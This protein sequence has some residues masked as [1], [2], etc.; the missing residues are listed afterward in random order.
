MAAGGVARRLVLAHVAVAAQHLHAEVAHLVVRLRSPRHSP[1][2]LA[3][4]LL[5][6]SS[7]I[8]A[9]DRQSQKVAQEL[10]GTDKDVLLSPD[11]AF[12]LEAIR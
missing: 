7:V 9:R 5:K 11:V 1:R 4:V 10:V 6:R 3:R 2:W 8:I 12:S